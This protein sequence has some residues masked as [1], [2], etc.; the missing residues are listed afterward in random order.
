MLIPILLLLYC[1]LLLDLYCAI[2]LI[3]FLVRMLILKLQRW[4]NC[5]NT[6]AFNGLVFGPKL[7]LRNL[8]MSRLH[9]GMDIGSVLNGLTFDDLVF[10]PH[11]LLR[12]LKMSRL[13][14]HGDVIRVIF[15]QAFTSH[16]LMLVP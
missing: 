14:L 13:D 2:I 10:F 4:Y 6:F 16:C 9:F 3:L 7:L 12:D 11:I 15:I 8:E 1:M 5:L